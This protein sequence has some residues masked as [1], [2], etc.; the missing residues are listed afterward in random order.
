MCSRDVLA[1]VLA[2]RNWM[3]REW[4][5]ISFSD[6][7]SSAFSSTVL[8]VDVSCVLHPFFVHQFGCWA[9]TARD[10]CPHFQLSGGCLERWGSS[11][12]FGLDVPVRRKDGF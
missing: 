4:M 2:S 8:R 11:R 6:L 12:L 10:D 3:V 7:G 9:C 1:D 5:F